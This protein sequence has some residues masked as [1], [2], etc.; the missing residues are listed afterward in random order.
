MVKV[1]KVT[2]VGIYIS[3]ENHNRSFCTGKKL[4]NAPAIRRRPN[5]AQRKFGQ[6]HPSQSLAERSTKEEVF[7]KFDQ[8]MT[9]HISI[10]DTLYIIFLTHHIKDER[11]REKMLTHEMTAARKK[12]GNVFLVFVLSYWMKG[13]GRQFAL[14]CSSKLKPVLTRA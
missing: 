2:G 13:F 4:E 8:F 14:L 3:R 9:H 12:K 1:E 6:Q 7:D 5:R 10:F 11:K